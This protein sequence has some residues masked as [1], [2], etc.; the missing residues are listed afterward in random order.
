[1]RWLEGGEGCSVGCV[2]VPVCGECEGSGG[3]V[4]GGEVVGGWM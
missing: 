2:V 3:G 4:I 1:M